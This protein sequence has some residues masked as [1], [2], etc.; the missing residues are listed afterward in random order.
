MDQERER[1]ITILAKNTAVQ[2]GETKLNIIDTPGHADFGGEVERGLTMVDGV[3]LL[4]D[5]AEGPL[6]QTR[7]VLR[8]ALEAGCRSC[9]SSTRST[10]PTRAST[11]SST[12]SRSCSWTST[13]TRTSS[14]SRSSSPT[15]R[16]ARR[17]WT[18]PRRAT[19][20]SRC[21]TCS[22]RRSRRRPT[23]PSHPAQAL[24]TNL[25]ADPY[26]G[27]L[28]VCRVRQGTIRK[29]DIGWCRA[30]GETVDARQDHR[31]VRHRRPAPRAGR[32]GRAGRDLRRRRPP[33]D[34]DRR[35]ARRRRRPAAAAGPARRR[36]RRSASRSPSTTSP[37]AGK[38]GNKLT[39]RQ[40]QARLDQ[41]LIGNVSIRVETP[42]ARTP[43]RS[44]AAASCSSRCSSRRCAARA[45]SCSS[46]SRASSRARST[47]PSTSRWSA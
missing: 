21:S 19:T 3:L 35:D 44:R 31:A 42:S 28:G 18:R 45:S 7:F 46:A 23:S 2:Y 17:R 32:R 6:P 9:S 11:R 20:S 37:F 47:A 39:A 5:A 25:D 38:D 33:G 34:H 10:A 22:S 29:G 24:V 30:D 43:G 16:P 26:L 13:P 4:V 12:R 14:S 1:G 8:K 40:I 27:R 36:A 15:P 41:E